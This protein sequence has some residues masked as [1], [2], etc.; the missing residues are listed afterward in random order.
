MNRN[1]KRFGSIDKEFFVFFYPENVTK[2]SE[3]MDWIRDRENKLIPDSDPGVEKA[4][5]S[6][7]QH[8]VA[9]AVS[10]GTVSI[11]CHY[12]NPVINVTVYVK[13]FIHG[14]GFSYLTSITRQIFIFIYKNLMI[15]VHQGPGPT[16]LHSERGLGAEPSAYGRHLHESAQTPRLSGNQYFAFGRK[17]AQWNRLVIFAGIFF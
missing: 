15:C 1:R 3:N 14:A 4:S 16:L 5:D 12:L 6:Y 8:T 11:K 13:L 10:L 2:L 9:N 7:P 17:L